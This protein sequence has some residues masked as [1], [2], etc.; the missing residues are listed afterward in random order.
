MLLSPLHSQS[1]G[2]L[3]LYRETKA[4]NAAIRT[5][6][7]QNS[8]PVI[9]LIDCVM[10]TAALKGPTFLLGLSLNHILKDVAETYCDY[11]IVQDMNPFIQQIKKLEG[12]SINRPLAM[13][14]L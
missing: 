11:E 4:A 9:H 1:H 2:S 10:V 7:L 5:A 13:E 8:D 6:K 14:A 12:P 3:D